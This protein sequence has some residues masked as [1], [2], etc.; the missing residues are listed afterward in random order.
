MCSHLALPLAASA[1]TAVAPVTAL[2]AIQQPPC[3]GT[4]VAAH[5]SYWLSQ[6]RTAAVI[7]GRK[8]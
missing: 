3:H 8:T 7:A 2:V 6:Q 5:Q 4:V 1:C